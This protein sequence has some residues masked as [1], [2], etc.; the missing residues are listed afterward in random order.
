MAAWWPDSAARCSPPPR[1]LTTALPPSPHPFLQASDLLR[2]EWLLL[3]SLGWRVRTPTAFT[4][5]L[6][7]AANAGAQLGG[8][9][10]QAAVGLLVGVR[11]PAC[12]Q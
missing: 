7:F 9:V 2:M 8:D 4:F 5:V 1:L 3:H 6:L 10:L 12:S 11:A